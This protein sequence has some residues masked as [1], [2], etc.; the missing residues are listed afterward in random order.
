MDKNTLSISF[1]LM[2]K[3]TDRTP[4]HI[5]SHYSLLASAFPYQSRT[6]HF[7]KILCWVPCVGVPHSEWALCY[8]CLEWKMGRSCMWVF[9]L[10]LPFFYCYTHT[11]QFYAEWQDLTPCHY[12]THTYT[13]THTHAQT[14]S[15]TLL[16][17]T[18]PSPVRNTHTHTVKMLLLVYL[19]SPLV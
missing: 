11:T 14:S 2:P 13:Y 18:N 9:E 10:L 12:H 17:R 8:C 3:M 1:Q 4:T 16:P 7:K 6:Q 19:L 15:S 5:S